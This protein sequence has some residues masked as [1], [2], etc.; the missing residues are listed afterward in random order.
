MKTMTIITA[1]FG[2][3]VATNFTAVQAQEDTNATTTAAAAPIPE[4]KATATPD[5]DV[6]VSEDTQGKIKTQTITVKDRFGTIEEQRVQS[7]YSEIRYVP[8]GSE[9]GYNL[10]EATGSN[11]TVN[12]EHSTNDNDLK[13]PSWN[14]FSW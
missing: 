6:A 5:T 13:I 9:N 1:T 7:M 3:L 4:A 14:L 8:N 10:I 11:G 12:S 2:V